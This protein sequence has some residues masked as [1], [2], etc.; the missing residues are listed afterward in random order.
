MNAVSKDVPV[1]V[2]IRMGTRDGK[3]TALKL[4]RR[5]I[6]GKQETNPTCTDGSGVAAITLHGRSRQQRYTKS[7]DWEYISECAALIKRMTKE[8]NEVADTVREEDPRTRPAATHGK[9]FFLGNG[10]CYSHV[11]YYNHL[12]QAGVDSVMLGRGALIKPW[13]FEEI[14]QNQY[15]DK[16]ASERLAYI[17]RFARYGLETWGSDEIGIGTTRRFLLEWLSFAHRYVPIGI[18]E[19]LPPKIQDRPPK[20]YGRNDLET[21]LGSDNY[22]DWI[23][24]RWVISKAE[25]S[26]NMLDDNP[27]ILARCSLDRRTKISDMSLSID[28]THMRR[29]QKGRVLVFAPGLSFNP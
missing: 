22:K 5:L 27:S 28:P 14:Q 7:A 16:S 29:K 15:L 23:K 12:E 25:V 20:W 13:I 3:P 1:T 2:K 19:R 11:D 24:I 10:D 4:A 21:L 8:Q 6:L 17:E 9:V 18:L 26:L